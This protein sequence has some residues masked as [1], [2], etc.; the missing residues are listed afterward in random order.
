MSIHK[1]LDIPPR[2]DVVNERN[3]FV[4]SI[5]RQMNGLMFDQGRTACGTDEPEAAVAQN[6]PPGIRSWGKSSVRKGANANHAENGAKKIRRVDDFNTLFPVCIRFFHLF[7]KKPADTGKPN[8]RG[9]VHPF[10]T[11]GRPARSLSLPT[12]G[13]SSFPFIR[14]WIPAIQR[15]PA[16]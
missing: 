15:G 9:D 11:F 2:D 13:M 14:F 8:G 10:F 5:P 4:W 7:L 1:F 12:V 3:L 16:C 6:P